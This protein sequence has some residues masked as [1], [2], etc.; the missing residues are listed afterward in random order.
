MF[1][2]ISSVLVL[3]LFISACGADLS[4]KFESVTVANNGYEEGSEWCSDFNLTVDEVSRFFGKAKELTAPDYHNE[5]Q[6]IGCFVKGTVKY[7]ESACKFTVWAGA[8][9]QL[10][11]GDKEYL[12]GCK[13]CEFTSP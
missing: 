1:K 6:H 3:G 7:K 9:A 8:T 11:C 5:Y 12:L 4:S 2:K 13:E 10:E